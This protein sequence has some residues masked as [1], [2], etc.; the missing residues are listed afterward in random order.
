MRK[1][2][3]KRIVF[4]EITKDAILKALA[5]KRCWSTLSWCSTSKKNFEIEQLD[6]N[7]S[8]LWKKVRYGLS[9]GR[10]Q[11]V[12]VRIIV[13]RENEIRAFIPEEYWKIKADFINPELKAELAK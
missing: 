1:N 8:F 6:M 9:A 7:F 3:I 13:D 10:V 12:A 4:H 11:S 5:K 2:P